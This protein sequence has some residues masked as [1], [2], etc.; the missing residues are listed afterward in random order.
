M[1]RGDLFQV[2]VDPLVRHLFGTDRI[3]KRFQDAALGEAWEADTKAE[4]AKA[5]AAAKHGLEAKIAGL[6]L[7]PD[8]TF[9][10]AAYRWIED[11]PLEA[12]SRQM[13]REHIDPHLIPVFGDTKLSAI[14]KPQLLEHLARRNK[15]G[16]SPRQL[17][18]DVIFTQGIVK[19]A[20]DLGWKV[21]ATV[22]LVA[23]P[24]APRKITRPFNPAALER[25]IA[26][27]E[28]RDRVVAEVALATGLRSKELRAM[29]CSWIR[30][31]TRQV[32]VPAAFNKSKKDRPLP[33][34][35]RLRSVLRAWL[36][37][38]TDGPVFKPL[39]SRGNS[40][41]KGRDMRRIAKKLRKL[42]GENVVATGL[43]DLRHA[44]L[45]GLA[46]KGLEVE[47]LR[48]LAGHSSVTVTELYMHSA[49]GRHIDRARR[50]LDTRSDTRKRGAGSRR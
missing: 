25:A 24:K 9:R 22:L 5:V 21:D 29:D 43:H 18:L 10:E 14:G 49:P 4:V 46:A 37:G 50:L 27:L 31:N 11:R 33:M 19:Y 13:Y 2:R 47:E 44:Y 23:K 48:K 6:D 15:A 16:A 36:E 42:A 34:G 3:R 17:R 41:S 12:S 38:R 45:S 1:P 7:T 35:A 28:P 40:P 8:V 20:A 39:R 30:W 32:V 26:K